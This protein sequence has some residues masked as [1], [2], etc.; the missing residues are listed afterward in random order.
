MTGTFDEWKQYL[1]EHPKV[2][3]L[4]EV[5]QAWAKHTRIRDVLALEAVEKIRELRRERD[6]LIEALEDCTERMERA[7][8][9]M[10]NRSKR[11]GDPNANWG[12]LDTSIACAILSSV[13]GNR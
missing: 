5:M 10:K 7:R 9:L 6:Q 1:F 3:A 13:K 4:E 12:M 2:D 8:R 11:E